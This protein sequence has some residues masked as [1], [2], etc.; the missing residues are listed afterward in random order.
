M[1][2]DD[3]SNYETLYD[4]AKVT[5]LAGDPA[6]ALRIVAELRIKDPAILPTDQNFL[7]AITAYEQSK[8]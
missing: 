5:Y 8:K 4:L 6:A 2:A 1:A 3:P 7:T